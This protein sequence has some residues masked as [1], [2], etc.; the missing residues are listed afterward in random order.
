[1]ENNPIT[2][3]HPLEEEFNAGQAIEL[4]AERTKTKVRVPKG[5][6]EVPM[7]KLCRIA[8]NLIFAYSE[9]LKDALHLYVP[10]SDSAR[11]FHAS[12]V[13]IRLLSGSN[14]A[15]KT[16][17]AEAE[18][19]R[20]WRGIDPYEKRAK[21]NLRILACGKDGDH[22]GQVMWRKLWWPGAFDIVPDEITGE[23]R[24]VRADPNTAEGIAEVDLERRDKWMPSPPLVP[25]QEIKNIAWDKMNLNIPRLVTLKNGSEAMF[26]TSKGSP[27]QGIDLDLFHCDEEL[28]NKSW[29]T[30]SK[31]R[32]LKRHGIMIAS[33]TPQAST[34]E[35]FDLHRRVLSGDASVE[36]FSLLLDEN[37]YI[38]LAAKKE[39]YN[40][41]K[42]D[43]DELD[44]R[45]FGKYA[46]AGRMVYSEWS[47]DM[48]GIE[49]FEVPD[50]WMRIMVVD[51]G[52]R[53]Q[54]ALFAAVSPEA[55]SIHL[56][57]EMHL[58][59]KTAKDVAAAVN[60]ETGKNKFEVFI[61]DYRG[62]RQTAMG[63]SDTI[64]DHYSE[65][66]A[67]LGVQSRVSGSNFVWGSDQVRGR[68][69]S[70]K[71]WIQPVGKG[72]TILRVHLGKC[73]KLCKQ[74]ESRYYDKRNPGKRDDKI[75]HDL[76][77]CLEYLAAYFDDYKG[78]TD[79]GLYWELPVE[80]KKKKTSMETYKKRK[81][82]RDR[83]KP[84]N[85]G[86]TFGPLS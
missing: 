86:M 11:A 9:R 17:T 29:I 16:T 13:H 21:N 69:L 28:E 46:I 78:R 12:K 66:L 15:G 58:Q 79:S 6:A 8:M 48:L 71:R 18:F 80:A 68:E 22:I 55:E 67:A 83:L 32:L 38:P 64:A 1:L 41:L 19:A 3:Q 4:L 10:I 33:Y 70:L 34:P 76:V 60:E 39:L 23:W 31:A 43:P 82:A 57:R 30:E 65:E 14:Q 77:D 54:A 74:V 35:Y 40:D 27:R 53:Y 2:T 51:P 36:E 47:M 63:H 50:D 81:A 37:P 85:Q 44:V 7:G 62:G 61:I 59:N 73:P 25:P 45:Y 56:Y 72:K 49:P 75:T 26:H 52:A 5:S 42:D 24:V 84:K 20:I